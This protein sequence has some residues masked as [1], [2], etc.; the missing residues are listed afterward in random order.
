MADEDSAAERQVILDYVYLKELK[1]T[2]V[3]NRHPLGT[4]KAIG[5]LA[6]VRATNAAVADGR[7]EVAL[8]V[9]IDASIEN[10]TVMRVR[11]IQAGTFLISG[12]EPD[13]LLEILGRICP[14]I[15]YPY[16]RATLHAALR[17]GGYQSIALNTMD[18]HAMFVQHML[19]VTQSAAPG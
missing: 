9:G 17:R 7:I 16:A 13:E 18:F 2:T 5:R 12:Y 6:N 19:N 10:E 3:D 8:N 15:L 14:E 1:F 4:A 11:I